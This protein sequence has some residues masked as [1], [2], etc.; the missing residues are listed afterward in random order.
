MKTKIYFA[1][2]EGMTTFIYRSATVLVFSSVD[3]YFAPF[4]MPHMKCD[5]NFKEQ[6]DLAR[7]ITGGFVLVPQF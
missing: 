4:F 5:F 6:K 3:K 7:R 1:P 2:L